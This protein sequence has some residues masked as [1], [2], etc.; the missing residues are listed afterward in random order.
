MQLRQILKRGCTHTHTRTHTHMHTH[1]HAST[2][3]HAHKR[4][5]AYTH[6]RM[7]GRACKRT[8]QRICW[9]YMYRTCAGIDHY[10][11]C[12]RHREWKKRRRCPR[13]F[14]YRKRQLWRRCCPWRMWQCCL[15]SATVSFCELLLLSKDSY[16][17]GRTVDHSLLSHNFGT[18]IF[19]LFSFVLILLSHNLP[20]SPK[21]RFSSRLNE[22]TTVDSWAGAVLQKTKLLEWKWL[23]ILNNRFDADWQ[24]HGRVSTTKSSTYLLI[25]E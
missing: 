4:T 11:R 23:K 8:D 22:E 1:T 16:C 20:R 21:Y 3:T 6:T 19:L 9:T 24:T 17:S 14:W 7:Q 13:V 12:L 10:R 18:L 25:V 2:H 5:Y 15:R